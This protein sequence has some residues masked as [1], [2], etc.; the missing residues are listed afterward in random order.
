MVV[1]WQMIPR[2]HPQ[3]G[4]CDILRA[5]GKHGAPRHEFDGGGRTAREGEDLFTLS[6]ATAGL[7]IALR[8]LGLP[9]GGG[10]AVPIY[11]CVTVF[12]AVRRAGLRCVFVDID[13]TTFRYDLDSLV[14]RRD[15]VD[16]AI[17]V[18][19][20]GYEGNFDGVSNLLP[21]R[22]I[23]EDCSHALGSRSGGMP[24]G[25][26]GAVSAFSFNFHKPV[27]AGGGGWL[28]VNEPALLPAVRR[29][30]EQLGDPPHRPAGRALW[31][32]ML[33][34]ALYRRP[35]YGLLLGCGLLHAD[36]PGTLPDVPMARMSHVEHTLISEGLVGFADRCRRYRDWA[37]RLSEAAGP[38]APACHF[39]AAGDDWNGYLWPVVLDSRTRREEA[40]R[41]FRRRG[42]DA[43]LLWLECLDAAAQYGYRR[44]DCPQLE[45]AL[46]RLMMLPSYAEL[47]AK[48]QRRILQAVKESGLRQGGRA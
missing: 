38:L 30:V 1:P 27:S 35:W 31:Q 9:E 48:Q 25:L 23:I 3:V 45:D 36:R 17:L 7:T 15:A 21:G 2:Y 19:T 44:G 5:L 14:H 26:R 39:V 11:T 16:A 41:F 46:G 43:Y 47:T 12:E 40:V 18:H 34:A 24:L 33:K 10:V 37:R 28:I 42:V 29:Q 6:G 32:R 13:P 22:P 4:P 8:A 20:F